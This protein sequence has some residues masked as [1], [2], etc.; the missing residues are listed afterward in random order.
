MTALSLP[1]SPFHKAPQRR[2][3]RA[4]ARERLTREPRVLLHA[5]DEIR[6]L[7]EPGLG[8]DPAEKGDVDR[9]AV[10]FAGEIEQMHFEQRRPVIER[11]AADRK[12]T[13]LNSRHDQISY[14]VFCLKKKKKNKFIFT[15]QKKKKTINKT[16]K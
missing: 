3:C 7:R 15:Y 14:A 16:R 1:R 9:R 5:D 11:R 6:D 13:R 2:K 12:S 4:G 8:P 10:E